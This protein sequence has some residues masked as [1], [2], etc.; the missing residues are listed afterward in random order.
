MYDFVA[1]FEKLCVRGMQGKGRGGEVEFPD[2]NLSDVFWA[3]SHFER[4]EARISGYSNRTCKYVS[5]LTLL[6]T[7][8]TVHTAFTVV[9]SIMAPSPESYL[10]SETRHLLT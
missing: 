9:S 3:V 2:M 1:T 4:D 8:H 10:H 7:V 6:Y 5:D